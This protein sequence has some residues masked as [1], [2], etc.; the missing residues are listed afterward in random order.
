M[1]QMALFATFSRRFSKGRAALA[2]GASALLFAMA[3]VA[4]AADENNT[5]LETI[6][7][8]GTLTVA[9]Y[10]D[11]A[12]FS[13]DGKGIDVDLAGALAAKL[14]VKMLP[15]WFNANEKLVDDLRKMVWN[16][17][18]LSSP[19]DLLMHVP[20][21][22]R[23]MSMVEK[24]KIFAPYHR[25]R[26]A[27]GRNREQLPA[28]ENLEPFEKQTFAVAGESMAGD[29]MLSADG[30]RYSKNARIFKETEDAI[31][32][33]KSGAVAAAFGEQGELEG[34]LRDDAR[35]AIESPPHPLLKQQW[36]VGLAVKSDSTELATALQSAMDELL[37]D[38]TVTR[39]MQHYGV[40][41]RRP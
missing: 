19:A 27:I 39:I 6:K 36:S 38:G 9:F 22:P 35:F 4:H 26:F 21:D 12:P 23:L 11:Y 28:L 18:P 3:P 1:T 32:A 15:I 24:V 20:V 14:G 2:L 31:N 41:D 33:L 25:E 37:A 13:N 40:Q 7:Q 16:G 5:A 30:G 8:R 17:T 34:A 29:V 10:K